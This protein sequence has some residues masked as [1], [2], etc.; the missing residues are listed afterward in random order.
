[1]LGFDCPFC[2]QK[3]SANK[4]AKPDDSETP[5]EP[6]RPEEPELDLPENVPTEPAAPVHPENAVKVES[7][8]E[9]ADAMVNAEKGAY[10][11]LADGLYDEIVVTKSYITLAADNAIGTS[12][13]T[14]VGRQVY[15]VVTDAFGD[16]VKTETIVIK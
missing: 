15:C 6:E 2:G 8:A 4:P 1:M 12:R 13:Q 7:A 5:E 10:N 16:S 11:V 14:R 3:N 9:L